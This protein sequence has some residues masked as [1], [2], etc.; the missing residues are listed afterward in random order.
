M[1]YER[2][3]P[4]RPE[5]LIPDGGRLDELLAATKTNQDLRQR[6]QGTVPGRKGTVYNQFALRYKQRFGADPGTFAENAYDSGYL[7]AY[8]IL[9]GGDGVVSGSNIATGMMQMSDK[10]AQEIVVGANQLNDAFNALT[11]S[12]SIDFTGASGDLDFDNATG[13]APSNIDIWCVVL[14]NKSDAVFVSSG[15]FYDASAGTISGA[16]TECD[17]GP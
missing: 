10:N 1:A 14:D 4:P 17:F 11:G 12:G 5:Y 8:A 16:D 9:A 3:A 7:A 13:E 15:Q 6:V 2:H